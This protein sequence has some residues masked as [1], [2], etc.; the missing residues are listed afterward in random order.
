MGVSIL[1][2]IGLIIKEY[3]SHETTMSTVEFVLIFLSILLFTLPI[4]FMKLK[5]RIDE[6]GIHYQFFPFHRSTKTISWNI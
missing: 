6:Y 5:T 4:F 1:V 3:T 2:P